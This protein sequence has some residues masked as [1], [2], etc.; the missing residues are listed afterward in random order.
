MDD[1][2]ND[3]TEQKVEQDKTD[4]INNNCNTIRIW[5]I[6][7]ES[8]Y[9]GNKGNMRQREMH[10]NRREARRGKIEWKGEREGK[11]REKTKK[12]KKRKKLKERRDLR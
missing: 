9:C 4:N 8:I 5:F 7:H 11:S 12:K 2:S 10:G 1:K 3:E 6:I